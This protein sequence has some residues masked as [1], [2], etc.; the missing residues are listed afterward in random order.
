M[1]NCIIFEVNDSILTVKKKSGWLSRPGIIIGLIQELIRI[2]NIKDIPETVIDLNDIHMIKL[3][4]H[5]FTISAKKEDKQYMIPDPYSLMWPELYIKNS[6][7][8]FKEIADK[9]LIPPI[10]NKAFWA[11]QNCHESRRCVVKLS[12]KYPEKIKASFLEWPKGVVPTNYVSM[13]D[14]T[15]YKYLIDCSGQGWSARIKYLLHSRRLLFLLDREYWDWITCDLVEW[16]HYVPV[17]ADA[18][19]LLEKIDW[20]DNNPEKVSEIIQNAYNFITT[21]L[22]LQN[23]FTRTYN[24][25]L[26]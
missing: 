2:C 14:Q 18:S 1:Q 19:D 26:K 7:T 8:K 24:I 22:T 17:K 5:K 12:E 11:G 3:G 25:L 16:E 21:N 23:I 4:N 20:A 10:Y 15:K 13:E 6:F 9:G